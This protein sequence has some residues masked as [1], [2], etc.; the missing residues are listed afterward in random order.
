MLPYQRREKLP[1]LRGSMNVP[2][3]SLHFGIPARGRRIRV[4]EVIPDQIITGAGEADVT[5]MNGEA[6]A[7]PN[8]DLLKLAVI[9]RHTGSGRVGLGFVQGFGLREGALAST[10]AHDAHNLIVVGASDG[11]MRTAAELILEMQGGLV[12]VHGREV[13]RLPL[14]IG[15]LMSDQPLSAV[16][17]TL[18]GLLD[19]ARRMGST[20]TDPFMT[21]SFMALSV[22]PALKLTDHGLLD[23]ER[24]NL[25]PLFIEE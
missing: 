24:F 18:R 12:A 25:V 21:L 20:L 2:P 14:P 10:V 23:V 8:R 3:S 17:E 11:D 4:I 1:A 9:E 5:I 15:G 19:T 6:A 7:D 22:I 13:A 16:A